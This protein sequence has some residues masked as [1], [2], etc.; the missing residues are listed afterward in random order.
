[1]KK[2]CH[3]R[4]DDAD[5]V[6]SE[7]VEVVADDRAAPVMKTRA[8][9]IGINYH[10]TKSQLNGCIN[11]VNNVYRFLTSKAGYDAREIRVLTDDKYVKTELRPTRANIMAGIRWLLEATKGEDAGSSVKLFLH[12]SGHGSWV[13]DTSGDEL[14]R[15]DETICPVDYSTHGM[16]KDDEL[17]QQLVQPLASMP[18]VNLTC[19]FDCCHSGTMLDL[20]YEYEVSVDSARLDRR[21]FRINQ[22][23]KVAKTRANVLLFSGS[24]DTQTAA[25]AYIAGKSQGA[26]TWAF[27][28][29][30]KKYEDKTCSLKRFLAEV[31][32]LLKKGGYKQVPHLCSSVHRPL[33]SAFTLQKSEVRYRGVVVVGEDSEDKD[34][35]Q[36]Q[37]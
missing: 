16:I 13:R 8:L 20:R 31:Q 10:G 7:V 32:L 3:K 6:S 33:N 26:M 30:L 12:Y 36:I 18:H 11:D 19:L 2:F 28:Q 14:D 17:H 35:P 15:R 22:N 24:L 29:V 23:K 34:R 9:L 27:L 4:D 21:S 37:I 5:L 1:M 25:D